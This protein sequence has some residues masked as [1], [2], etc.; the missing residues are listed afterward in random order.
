MSDSDEEFPGAPTSLEFWSLEIPPGKT[1]QARISDNPG[2]AE[3]VHVTGAALGDNP[4]AGRH[5]LKAIHELPDGSKKREV[6][7][8]TLENG[9]TDQV[10]VDFGM[11]SSMAF[12]HTGKSVVFL[13]GYL[14]RSFADFED[15]DSDDEYD[16]DESEAEDVEAPA[17]VPL[18]NGVKAGVR[19]A[20]DSD[21]SGEDDGEDEDE[22]EEDEGED[23]DKYDAL[24]GAKS[25]GGM[26]LDATEGGDPEDR[27][28]DGED[29]KSDD[30]LVIDSDD[31]VAIVE[32][33]PAANAGLGGIA[34]MIAAPDESDEGEDKDEDEDEDEDESDEGEEEG[35]SD[36]E[37]QEAPQVAV[38]RPAQPMTPQPAQAEKRQKRE[39]GKQVPQSAPAK[40]PQSKTAGPATGGGGPAEQQ[41][42]QSLVQELQK[43]PQLLNKLSNAVKKPKEVTAKY[44]AFLLQHAATFRVN[45]DQVSLA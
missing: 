13:S 4:A 43:G 16:E 10:A 9:R 21:G 23:G 44:K 5:V 41:F 39:G 17:A 45:G 1:V 7:L 38:K 24:L 20:D 11:S 28:S 30:P 26:E 6:A 42:L 25:F 12:K 36:E 19:Q 27:V 33:A 32:Y 35:E 22:S 15:F 8:G 3:V 2:V 18:A 31:L 34:G 29:D 14:T 40:A 37:L